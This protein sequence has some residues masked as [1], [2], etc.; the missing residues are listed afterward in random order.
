MQ[1][2]GMSE[3]EGIFESLVYDPLPPL[4]TVMLSAGWVT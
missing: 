4:P 1:A 2:G 3:L